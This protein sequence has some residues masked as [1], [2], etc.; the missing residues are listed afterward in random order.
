MMN[1]RTVDELKARLAEIE[2]EIKGTKVDKTEADAKKAKVYN[3]AFWDHMHTGMPANALKEGGDGA[4]GY[5]VPDE[6]DERLVKALEDKNI[7]RKLGKCMVTERDLKIPVSLSDGEADWIEEGKPMTFMDAEFGQVRI[8]A[9]KLAAA[10][11]CTDEMLEDSGINL[12]NYI[13]EEFASALGEKEEEAFFVGDGQGKPTGI[14]YQAEVAEEVSVDELSLDTALDLMYSVKRP[15]RENG[16]VYIMSEDAYR[17]LRKQKVRDGKYVWSRN[18]QDDEPDTLFGA[19]VYVTKNLP[20][21]EDGNVVMLYGDFSYFWIG[22]RG[23]RKMKRLEERYAEQG[24][25]A[26]ITSQRVDA[27]LVLP[28]AVKSV[29]IKSA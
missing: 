29:K 5:L 9:F 23:K 1:E 28:E 4:G 16:A 18:L 2:A 11:R 15:Y 26:F 17:T 21:L 13:E 25:V 27:K 22:D 6:Y 10:I 7:L 24:L 3:T 20:E 12:E 19:P 14:V 8:G